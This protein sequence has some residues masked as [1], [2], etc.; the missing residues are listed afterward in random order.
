MNSIVQQV[1]IEYCEFLTHIQIA[2]RLTTP[3]LATTTHICHSPD[4]DSYI[5]L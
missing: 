1:D 5:M 2:F 3:V 4:M